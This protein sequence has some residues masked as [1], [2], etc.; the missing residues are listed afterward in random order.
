MEK[1]VNAARARYAAVVADI[2]EPGKDGVNPHFK[3]EYVTLAGLMAHI[4]PAL[5]DANLAVAQTLEG[6]STQAFVCTAIICSITGVVMPAGQCPIPSTADA[7]KMGSAIT[8]IRRYS[9]MAA[10]GLAGE[11]DDGTAAVAPAEP[12]SMQKFSAKVKES[13]ADGA[14]VRAQLAERFRA[15]EEM[16]D[17]DWRSALWAH[18]D[19]LKSIK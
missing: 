1:D 5:Q 6:D 2:G 13:G 4:R 3:N 17:S 15:P 18:A 9:L 12:S 16:T 19:I 14:K 11:D 10:F 8:Y 7:Q